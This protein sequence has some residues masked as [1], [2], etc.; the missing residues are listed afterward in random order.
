MKKTWIVQIMS[1]RTLRMQKVEIW[2]QEIY[3]GKETLVKSKKGRSWIRQEKSTNHNTALTPIEGNMSVGHGKQNWP[4]RD[5]Q[6]V[7]LPQPNFSNP[8]REHQHKDCPWHERCVGQWCAGPS[9]PA[10]PNHCVKVLIA[11]CTLRSWVTSSFLERYLGSE[12]PWLPL[13]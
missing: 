12:P 6:T 1:V 7:I 11:N 5:L 13:K 8:H 2:V 10:M 9:L 3:L 4:E